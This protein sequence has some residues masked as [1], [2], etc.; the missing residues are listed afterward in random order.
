MSQIIIGYTTEG[1]TD[2]RFLSSIILRTFIEVGPECKKDIEIIEPIVFVEKEK[3]TDFITQ[4]LAVSDKANENGVMVL[5]IHVDADDVNDDLVFRT[6]INPVLESIK[7]SD[8]NLCKTIVPVVPV[9]MTEAWML[10][11]KELLKEEIGTYKSDKELGMDRLPESS[12]DPKSIIN[13]AIIISRA[14]MVRRRRKDLSI[15]DLYLPLGQK[16]S[17]EKL[18]ELPSYLKFKKSIRDAYRSLNYLK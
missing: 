12:A 6:K 17:I 7:K 10:A 2:V 9:Q 14:D 1:N 13:N 4:M 11:D 15:S 5:C 3:G 8:K 16:I 18:N